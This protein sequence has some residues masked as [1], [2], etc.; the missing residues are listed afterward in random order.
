MRYS[1]T[2]NPFLDQPFAYAYSVMLRPDQLPCGVRDLIA[3]NNYPNYVEHYC[4][5]ATEERNG[6]A[7]VTLYGLSGVEFN[8]GW[9]RS[10]IHDF[11]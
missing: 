4:G 6:M 11:R 1:D 7:P 10:S 5:G 3:Q 2:V 9:N 8:M